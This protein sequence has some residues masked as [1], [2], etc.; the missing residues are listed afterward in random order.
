MT[1]P[2][3]SARR[4]RSALPNVSGVANERV[5]VGAM[6]CDDDEV[7]RAEHGLGRGVRELSPAGF[8]QTTVM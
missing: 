3:I 2:P 5:D 6:P 1:R 4:R 7:V 8:T